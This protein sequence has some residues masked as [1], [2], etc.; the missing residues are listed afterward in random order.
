VEVAP[1]APSGI[2]FLPDLLLHRLAVQAFRVFR[3]SNSL[4][5]GVH[6]CCQAKVWIADS[7]LT[8]PT[9]RTRNFNR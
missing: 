1:T 2:I 5:I 6:P 7:V 8:D 4:F 9:T 3:G